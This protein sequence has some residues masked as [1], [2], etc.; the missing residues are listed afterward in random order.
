MGCIDHSDVGLPFEASRMIIEDVALAK[1][2]SNTAIPSQGRG[3]VKVR[4]HELREVVF[5]DFW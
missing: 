1:V 3:R 2:P 4:F 5:E